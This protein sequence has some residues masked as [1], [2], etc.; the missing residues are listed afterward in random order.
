[1]V[2]YL[3]SWKPCLICL[4]KGNFVTDS[5]LYLDRGIFTF[6]QHFVNRFIG[7]EIRLIAVVDD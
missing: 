4:E 1:M 3:V 6:L 2:V 5:T 7:N